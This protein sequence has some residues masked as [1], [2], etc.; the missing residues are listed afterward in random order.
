MI[1]WRDV[2]NSLHE[3]YGN[4]LLSNTLTGLGPDGAQKALHLMRARGEEYI[5]KDRGILKHYKYPNM[6]LR[7]SK[8]AYISVVND[9]V[10]E[11]QKTLHKENYYPSLRKRISIT[12]NF[13]MD[14]Y[15]CPRSL[16]P[17]SGTWV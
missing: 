6:F 11:S 12:K 10:L 9:D 16:P 2:P 14:M 3:K 5:D 17:F 1:R 7:Q 13:D 15:Y 8:N 4:I